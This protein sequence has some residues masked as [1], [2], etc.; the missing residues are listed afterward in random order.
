MNEA[1]YGKCECCGKEAT[2]KRKYYYYYGAP[3]ECHKPE[4]HFELVR[5]CSD[6]KP[7]PPK[8]T[9]MTIDMEPSHETPDEP[10]A[11]KEEVCESRCSVF[12]VPLEPTP[13]HCD[14]CSKDILNI[15]GC[16][17][18]GTTRYLTHRNQ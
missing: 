18:C 16:P 13:V 8:T 10:V 2:L 4:E 9:T 17:N 6:C 14:G 5:H 11:V 1:E 15:D 12:Q 3:C 7:Q